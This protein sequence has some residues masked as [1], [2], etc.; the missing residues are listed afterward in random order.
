MSIEA[1]AMAGV[2]Y[3][4][5]AI[6]LEKWNPLCPQ[7]PPLYLVAEHEE[8]VN[9]AAE[10]MKAKIREWAKAVASTSKQQSA[11]KDNYMCLAGFLIATKQ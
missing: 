8:L 11:T 10:R 4:E 1:M 7:Q 9:L 2:D 3:K 6:T 5:C